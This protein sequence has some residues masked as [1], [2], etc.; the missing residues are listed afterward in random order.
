MR[1]ESMKNLAIG[2]R[3]S[4]AFLMMLLITLGVAASGY[5]GLSRITGV[6]GEMLSGDY[7]RSRLAAEGNST[8]LM[9]RRYEKDFLLNMGNAEAEEKYARE[10]KG[11]AEHFARLLDE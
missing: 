3:L 11:Q 2:L 8:V 10:W 9:L 5:W 1:G 4:F 6:V 7:Q